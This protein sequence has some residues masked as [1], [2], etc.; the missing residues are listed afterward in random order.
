MA[1][2]ARKLFL[3]AT[4]IHDAAQECLQGAGGNQSQ[5]P[6]QDFRRTG[7]PHTQL[8]NGSQAIVTSYQ[9][10]CCGDILE[11]QAYMH[12]GGRNF[13]EGVYTVHFQVWRPSPT[14][15]GGGCYSLVGENRFP[16][17]TLRNDRSLSET[18]APSNRIAVRPGD[19]LGYYVFSTRESPGDDDGIQMD[20]SFVNDVVHYAAIGSIAPM[21][22][23]VGPGGTLDSSINA[24]PVVS[25]DISKLG[26]A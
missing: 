8:P 24:G 2:H 13:R 11:W 15:G 7:E 12:Q 19:V 21:V 17:V 9:F 23:S 3:N 20:P 16:E 5:I 25:I 18:T 22:V 6:F 26:F 1:A 4:N 10:H 14:V